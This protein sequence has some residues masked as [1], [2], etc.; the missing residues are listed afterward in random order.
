M[1]DDNNESLDEDDIDIYHNQ[2]LIGFISGDYI[3][4]PS[5]IVQAEYTI[6]E[7]KVSDFKQK[8]GEWDERCW[9]RRS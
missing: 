9:F 5:S 8:K 2:Y 1:A 4:S 6:D 7:I 3:V